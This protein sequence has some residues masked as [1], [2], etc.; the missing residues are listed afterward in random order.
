LG[1]NSVPNEASTKIRSAPIITGRR[2][3]VSAT[4]PSMICST[5]V[6]SR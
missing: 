2:P 5:E 3:S 6:V 4:D 1:A